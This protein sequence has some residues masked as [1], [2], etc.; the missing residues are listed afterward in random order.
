MARNRR[1]LAA[2]GLS[3][4]LVATACGPRFGPRAEGG[5]LP[6]PQ[7][8]LSQGT[9]TAPAGLPT[10]G[11]P[12]GGPAIPTG[13]PPPARPPVAVRPGAITGNEIK[14]GGLFPRTG[15]LSALGE[16]AYR[17]AQATFDWVNANG[18]VRGKKIKF[19]P[20]D[21]QAVD[22]QSTTCAKK[23]VEQ[24]GIF[25]M[26]PSFTPFSLTVIGQLEEQGVP[27]VGFDGINIEGFDSP[28]VVTVGAPIEPMGHALV[29]YWYRK[30]ERD[31]G[32]A[33]KRIGAVVLDV[34]PART[35]IKIAR[36]RICPKLGCSIVREQAVNY[37]TTQYSTI[38][39][40]MVNRGVDAIWIITDPASA[41]KLLVQCAA[42]RP[43]KGFLGQH[44]IYLDLTIEEAGRAADGILANSAVLPPAVDN[45][46]TRE[47]KQIIRRSY[48][49]ATFG[50]FTALSYA[51]ARLVVDLI[52]QVLARG[53]PLTRQSV[54]DAAKRTTAY[55]CNGLCRSVN[56][57]PPARATGG[58]HNV[59][60]VR[61]DF[62]S[63][64]GKWVYETGPIDAWDT[65]TWPCPGR[66]C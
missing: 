64:R 37:Q 51:S 46:A 50:Y 53:D 52:D 38:C 61:A 33:P 19:I 60:I 32:S 9:T 25:L 10:T 22:T 16:A 18:G 7:Q 65:E 20:C 28:T 30:V 4:A 35:Y 45:A 55:S 49:D 17:G 23:L 54:L 44:G 34:A 8:P 66:P 42:Y 47:M 56:L 6:G 24:D 11:L 15:G 62:S 48:P 43:P 29:D 21:D 1:T 12:T 27:W 41:V 36:E 59:W 31:T 63:G 39:S 57:A 40:N 3:V 2:L 5:N 14:I 26:G 13:G 58:N